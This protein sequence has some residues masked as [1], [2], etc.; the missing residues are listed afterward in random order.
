[1]VVLISGVLRGCDFEADCEVLARK[2]QESELIAADNFIPYT[3]CQVVCA[4]DDVPDG[5][6]EISFDGFAFQ[7]RC[8]AGQWSSC[9]GP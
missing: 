9:S 5:E 7:A 2:H 4:R 6:Y 8:L 3:D 1:M